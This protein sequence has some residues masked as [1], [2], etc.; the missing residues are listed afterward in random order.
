MRPQDETAQME[1]EV[2][3]SLDLS[4]MDLATLV[5]HCVI[6]S[7]RFY[8]G[9]NND[10]RF[11][12]ELFRR[13]LVERNETAWNYVYT[14]YSTLVESWVR[15]CGA[16]TSSGETSEF[17]V[18]AA[19]TKFW[20][21]VTPD[22][23]ASFHSLPSLLQYLQMCATC[24]VI[25]SVRTQSWAEIVPESAMP[26]DGGPHYSPDEEALERVNRQD[27]W[28]YVNMQLHDDAERAVV[29]D[30]FVM[31]MKPGEI[32]QK[33]T[34]LFNSVRDVYGVKRNVLERLGRNAELKQMFEGPLAAV[35]AARPTGIYAARA[36]GA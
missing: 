24:V 33:R 20:R 27:F 14:H 13:A 1:N 19:F 5:R 29:Y 3:G 32:Y 21:A 11:A 18:V 23:F 15:R 31:G 35:H 8:S 25:D 9:K 6:E 17:F 4:K 12:Y 7:D 10:T 34:T 22:R 16:F 28:R 2:A 26:V 30:S 36:V